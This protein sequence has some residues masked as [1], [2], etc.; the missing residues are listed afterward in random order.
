MHCRYRSKGVCTVIRKYIVGMY[1]LTCSYCNN[2]QVTPKTDAQ[3]RIHPGFWWWCCITFLLR[4]MQPVP[5]WMR[6]I[7]KY[8][9]YKMWDEIVCHRQSSTVIH[10]PTFYWACCYLSMLALLRCR[11]PGL[12][13]GRCI[14][15][16]LCRKQPVM[17]WHQSTITIFVNF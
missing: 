9:H 1:K 8:I 12:M 5:D 3:F 11:H 13:W 6:R 2:T 10:H 14:T 4:R 7:S 16:L 17:D 15:R